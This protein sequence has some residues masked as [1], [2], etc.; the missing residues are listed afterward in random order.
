[1]A[2]RDRPELDGL[3]GYFINALALR[4]DLSGDPGFRGLLGR[5][6]E[7]ALGAFSHQDLPFEKLVEELKPERR[8]GYSPIFQ[9]VFNY[10]N[11]ASPAPLELP[12]LTLRPLAAGRGTAKYDLTL[13][14]W[15]AADRLAGAFEYK[16]DLFDAAAMARVCDELV[17]VLE[18]AVA[19]P[20]VR[21]SAL[22][23]ELS[24]RETEKRM[25]RQEEANSSNLKKL[26]IT[27]RR[28]VNLAQDDSSGPSTWRR[29]RSRSS[30]ARTSTTSTSPPGRSATPTSS[31]A[32]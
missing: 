31:S 4:T 5:V 23:D 12:G 9:V 16:T 8:P 27:K 22:R 26:K 15:E 10:Q 18:R 32:S 17:M 20:E 29:G 6:R 28:A 13:Y 24:A 25:I 21:L 1:M 7:V 11:A 19:N 30:S 3:I 14:M 2:G